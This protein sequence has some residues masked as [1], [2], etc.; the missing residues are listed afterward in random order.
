MS[1]DPFN[2]PLVFHREILANNATEGG[3]LVMARGLGLDS[4]IKT[5]IHLY[6]D[7]RVLVFVLSTDSEDAGLGILDD[8]VDDNLILETASHIHTI[9]TETGAKERSLIYDRGGV[10]IL[11]PRVFLMDLLLNR[12][13][14]PVVTGVLVPNA[15]R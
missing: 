14:I 9:K 10:I 3:L 1:E 15:H 12:V 8:F 6:A 5:F 13:P 2:V 7:P 4:I 11:S